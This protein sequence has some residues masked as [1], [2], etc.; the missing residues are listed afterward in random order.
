MSVSGRALK[1]HIESQAGIAFMER[2]SG[3]KGPCPFEED[4]AGD[5]FVVFNLKDGEFFCLSC[6]AKGGIEEFNR[7]WGEHQTARQKAAPPQQESAPQASVEPPGS[8]SPQ[9]SVATQ[10]AP[11]AAVVVTEDVRQHLETL[12]RQADGL[13]S[14]VGQHESTLAEIK[15][16][17][18]ERKSEKVK[19]ESDVSAQREAI[20]EVKQML[21]AAKK[22]RDLIEAD[23][24]L[25]KH[26]LTEIR[27]FLFEEKK[28][29]EK[30]ESESGPK[31]ESLTEIKKLLL[32][33]SP[34]QDSLAEI[35]KL[36]LE[37]REE[38]QKLESELRQQLKANKDLELQLSRWYQVK[39]ELESFVQNLENFGKKVRTEF[40][41]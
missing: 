10:T 21:I 35:K 32:E 5:S 24:R 29:R 37:S 6:K 31:Q 27:E 14:L 33:N 15:Q 38:R 8:F 41:K 40:L 19:A 2:P 7:L 1:E 23:V 36:L 3:W 13:L 39:S 30:R 22:N 17:L 4:L 9:R 20:I 12:Q 16:M 25:Q 34:Q 11:S 18:V 28:E 26:A